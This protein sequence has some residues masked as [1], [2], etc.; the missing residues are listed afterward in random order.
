MP[1]AARGGLPCGLCPLRRE[2]KREVAVAA[3][4]GRNGGAHA[5]HGT[6]RPQLFQ[7]NRVLAPSLEPLT[8]LALPDRPGFTPCSSTGGWLAV[9][10]PWW[11]DCTRA[12]CGSLLCV[13]LPSLLLESL[14][15]L[16]G[17]APL[18]ILMFSSVGMI[19]DHIFPG[20]VSRCHSRSPG[21]HRLVHSPGC[22]LS[23]LRP[24]NVLRRWSKQ[25]RR[26]SWK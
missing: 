7:H 3:S 17:A 18:K 4:F 13:V 22:A 10:S 2:L 11:N 26:V 9:S 23:I 19:R 6:A 20:E 21:S 1:H 12:C 24:G 5:V 14:A 25:E 8:R 16:K 15:L